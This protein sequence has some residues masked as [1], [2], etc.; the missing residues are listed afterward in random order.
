LERAQTDV[1]DPKRRLSRGSDMPVFEVIS[2]IP[3]TP[4][5]A[6]DAYT[7]VI[8]TL[9][10]AAI[11]LFGRE[12]ACAKCWHKLENYN[13]ISESDHICDCEWIRRRGGTGFADV[14]GAYVFDVECTGDP[15]YRERQAVQQL[16][17]GFAAEQV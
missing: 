2:E 10:G 13:A 7:P 3:V 9:P 12:M 17:C 15:G 8:R 6:L 4:P 11:P 14:R 1:N 16:P 5:A